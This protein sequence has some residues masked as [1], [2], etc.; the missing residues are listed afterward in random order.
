MEDKFG[1]SIVAEEKGGLGPR[2]EDLQH[3]EVCRGGI[4]IDRSPSI[5]SKVFFFL[6][7]G[8]GCFG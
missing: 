1:E 4:R 5:I 7:G 8:G 3:L 6:R 2:P